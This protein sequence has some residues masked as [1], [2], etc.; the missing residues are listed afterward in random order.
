MQDAAQA[1]PGRRSE[2]PGAGGRG[3]SRVEPRP[4]RAPSSAEEL[5]RT[6]QAPAVLVPGRPAGPDDLGAL[7]R[8]RADRTR[9]TPRSA[10]PRPGS[11]RSS[12]SPSLLAILMA[13]LYGFFVSIA[14]GMAIVPDDEARVGDMLLATPL[15]RASTSGGSSWRSSPASWPSSASTCCWSIFFNHVLPNPAAAGDPRAAPPDELPAAGAGLR[16]ADARLLRG[17]A[18]FLGERWRRPIPV[19]LFPVAVLIVCGFFLWDWAPT[20]LDPRINR[21]LM[22]IDPVG[23]PLAQRDLAQARP[24]ASDFYNTARIG[25]DAAVRALAAGLPRRSGCWASRWRSGTW[26][27]TSRGRPAAAGA[28]RRRGGGGRPPTPRA[29]RRGAAPARP[30]CGWPRRR[31]RL[32]RAAPGTSPAPS[33]GTSSPRPGVYLFG[34]LILLQTLGASLLALGP[35][36]TELLITPGQRRGARR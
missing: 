3:R 13:I 21:A 30:S 7:D 28:G 25:L 32:P 34:A 18:F 36:Q 9:A 33:C 12:P 24:R 2:A 1:P 26:P 22:L 20:W 4:H 23:L 15:A 14:A 31:D 5:A 29:R 6:V 27:R 16:A 35:F 11:P 17:V 8:A 10:A 19:F